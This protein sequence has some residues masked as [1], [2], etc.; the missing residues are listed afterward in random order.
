MTLPRQTLPKRIALVVV[1]LGLGA[2]AV[3]PEPGSEASAEDVA[4]GP[5][6]QPG[7][8][9]DFASLERIKDFLPPEFWKHR[10]LIFYEGMQMEIGPSFADYGPSEARKALTEEYG[11]QARIGRDDSIENYTL[12]RPFPTIAPDD[13]LRGIKHAWNMDYKHDALE[14]EGSFLFTYWDRGGEKLPLYYKGTG[15]LMRL[16]HRTDRAGNGGRIFKREKRK[17]AGGIE[18]T[19]PFDARGILA[20]GYRYLSSDGPRDQ[21]KDED[22]WVWIP[23]LRRVRRISGAR[24]QD[25]IAGTDFTPD[26]ARSFSGIVP[27]YSW[28][29]IGE[30]DVLSPVNTKRL[31]YPFDEN[32]NFGPTGFSLADDRWEL[33]HA[34]ILE[35]SPKE[36]G[37][38]YSRKQIWFD[39]QTYIPLFSVAYSRRAELWKLIYH[40][41]RWGE[42]EAQPDRIEGLRSFLPV[43]DVIMN[44]ISG[45]GNRVEFWDS[46]PTRYTKG[47]IRK[48]TDVGR[49]NRGR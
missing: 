45:T 3:P 42:T 4:P 43:C 35:Q 21:A 30:Q 6:F 28:E 48:L 46:R 34:I 29:F 26:D 22:V 12:G 18:V 15:W 47:G 27:Q 9:I 8:L 13:P 19:A 16:A 25:A 11:G 31:G 7:D 36:E 33:R 5:A 49:L 32:R 17:G 40:T 37:H 39:K 41:H 20:L 24:R 23:D 10:D 14:G 2:P 44:V 1:A 38:P